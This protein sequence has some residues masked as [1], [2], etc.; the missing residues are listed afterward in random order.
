GFVGAKTTSKTVGTTTTISINNNISGPDGVVSHS[1]RPYAGDGDST[2][3]VF[4]LDT[5]PASA[6]KASISTGGT[7]PVDGMARTTNRKLLLAANK[8]EDSP[9]ATLF[10]AN[11]NS[12]HNH[13]SIITNIMVDA[14]L[15][16]TGAGLSP[17][18]PSWEPRTKRLFTSIPINANNPTGCNF[19]QLP[20]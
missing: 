8:A 6:L 5:P 3:K 13:T 14:T 20:G 11:G 16:P 19:G 10:E 18:Q 4:D 7:T 9:F 2:L 12:A 15:M 17:E 1:R